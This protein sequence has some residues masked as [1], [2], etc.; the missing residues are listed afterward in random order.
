[1][2]TLAVPSLFL[3]DLNMGGPETVP[4]LPDSPV[5]L[6]KMTVNSLHSPLTTPF[7]ELPPVL[8]DPP[9]LVLG[10]VL[11]VVVAKVL[12]VVV[13]LDVV[14][15]VT[16][17]VVKSGVVT[18]VVVG[19]ATVVVVF[20][21]NPPKLGKEK[22]PKRDSRFA[23]AARLEPKKMRSERTRVGFMMKSVDLRSG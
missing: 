20:P 3:K 15:V 19:L 12:D 2:V 8:V 18:G 4:T 1:M 9:V 10:G 14:V 17:L 23:G 6:A 7:S 13:G 21:P 11:D 5:P 16:A 22:G